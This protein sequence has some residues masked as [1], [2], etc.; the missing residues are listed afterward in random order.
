MGSVTTNLV[1]KTIQIVK[2]I[3]KPK[4]VHPDY[5]PVWHRIGKFRSS[6]RRVARVS[7]STSSEGLI[8]QEPIFGKLE[9]DSHADTCVFGANFVLLSYT[10]RE[11]DVAPY[12]DDYDAVENVSIVAAATAWT[13]QESGET[14]ILVF[15]E[16]LWMPKSMPH[17]LV[18][19]NQLQA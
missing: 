11:C 4:L 5:S 19:P 2:K 17:S 6:M 18:N 15:N 12:S 3:G 14:F 16:G 7:S 8:P 10:G 9:L 13:C 1:C